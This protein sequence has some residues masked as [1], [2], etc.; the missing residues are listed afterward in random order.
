MKKPKKRYILAEGYPWA[1]GL[2]KP[3]K[4]YDAI[5]MCPE[6]IGVQPMPLNWPRELWSKDLPKFRLVLERIDDETNSA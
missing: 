3:E 5:Y 4:P 2:G 6:P 1:C